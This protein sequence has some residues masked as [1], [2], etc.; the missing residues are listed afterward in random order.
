MSMND[1]QTRRTIGVRTGGRSERVVN[2]VVHATLEEIARVGYGPLRVEDVAT[3]AGVNKT[4]VY[5]RWPTKSAL[6][7]AAIQ[8][9]SGFGEPVPDT[10]SARS[11][12]AAL[13]RR[14]VQV[15]STDEGRAIVRLFQSD[16]PDAEVEVIAKTIRDEARRRRTSILERAQG[17]GELSAD[18]DVALVL[19]AIVAPVMSR[20]LTHGEA[21]DDATVVRLVDLVMTGV[22]H[23]A[24]RKTA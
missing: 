6:V 22:E 1:G 5:R 7:T 11:D 17:R 21:V 24:G 20:I 14:A 13:M 18:V 19:D 10:G 3:R 8:T 9:I 12:L 16:P 15:A 4:S 2:A 23:G